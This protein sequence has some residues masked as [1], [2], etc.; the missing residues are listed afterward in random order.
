M[1]NFGTY[2]AIKQ[3]LCELDIAYARTLRGDN[4][5]FLMPADFHAWM[6]S[7][8]HTNPELMKYADDFLKEDLSAKRRYAYREP[9]L[10]YVWGHS[11]E[12]DRDN[13]WDV[14]EEFCKLMAGHE[15]IFYG[16]NTEVLLG[17]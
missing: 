4:N 1:G 10:F 2:E 14:I 13:N 8:H 3:Y 17:K 11:Y 7:A 15:D 6:P 9:R 16:T 12:F 5:Q